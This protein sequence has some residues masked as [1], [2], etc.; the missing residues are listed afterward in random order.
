MKNSINGFRV[1]L[2]IWAGRFNF[3]TILS[4]ALRAIEINGAQRSA[5]QAK[6]K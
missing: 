4:A 6:R 5:S 3:T 1:L 2:L